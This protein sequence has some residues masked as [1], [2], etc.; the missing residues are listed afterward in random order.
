MP[1]PERPTNRRAFLAMCG[2]AAV[3]GCGGTP[4]DSEST[5]SEAPQ[6]T[7]GE[8]TQRPTQTEV[9]RESRPG[10]WS[11]FGYDASNA[12]HNRESAPVPQTEESWS[13]FVPGYFT[14]PTPA[15][16]NIGVYMGS[17]SSMFAM[18]RTTGFQVWSER[19]G[20]YT[21]T[22][23]PAV[24]NE[25]VY[26]VSRGLAGAD[27]GS[28]T[29]GTIVAVDERTGASDWRTRALVSSSPTVADGKLYHAAAARTSAA[30]VARSTADGTEQWRFSLADGGTAGA[31]GTPAV[32]DGT[33]YATGWIATD[34][35]S[36]GVLYALDPATGDE[37]WRQTVPET[38]SIS[39]IVGEDTAVLAGADGTVYAVSLADQE[40]VW[41]RSVGDGVYARPAIGPEHVYTVTEGTLTALEKADGSVD[42]TAPVGE[43]HFSEIAVAGG[44][45]FVGGNVLYAYNA[46]DGTERWNREVPGYAG[47]WGGPAIVDGDMYVGV[48][49]KP[50]A[51]DLYDNYVYYMDG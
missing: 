38:L 29:P 48:C 47:A 51:G 37:H 34:D 20:P 19:L 45:V 8:T 27:S 13:T 9:P 15:V 21:H 40:V 1:S 4:G 17:K 33:V 36:D 3:A 43:S 49:I 16:S 23:T 32:L 46:A 7:T 10:S 35:G 26:A 39:P 6:S 41:T 28:N 42:W 2:A 30:I 22:F 5:T 44:A 50:E 11:S 31:F 12:G 14:L 18:D 25:T 24:A